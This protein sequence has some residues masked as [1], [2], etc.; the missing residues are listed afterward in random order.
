M[1]K[2]NKQLC[3]IIPI[4]KQKLSNVETIAVNSYVDYFFDSDIYF[5][6]PKSMQ[7]EWYN[8]K[9]N[10]INY[11]RFEDCYFKSNKSYNVMMLNTD[12]YEKFTDYKYMLIAQTDAI[13]F[14]ETK[15]INDFIKMD[16]DYIGA[17]WYTSPFCKKDGFF[18]YCIKRMVIHDSMEGKC[19]NGGFSL[20]KIAS[21][22]EMLENT[23]LYRKVLWHYNEDIFFSYIGYRKKYKIAPCKVAEKFAL[24]QNMKERLSSGDFPLAVHAWEKIFDSYEELQVIKENAMKG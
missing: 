6:C 12:F 9:F 2:N 18:K 3:V 23:K 4:Y 20:R 11:V 13:I 7:T 1:N 5:V 19:G 10:S 14:D 21:M 22:I 15:D 16:Y 8:K 17:P 24:E